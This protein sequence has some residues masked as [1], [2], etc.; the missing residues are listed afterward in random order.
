MENSMP[1]KIASPKN[2]K[3]WQISRGV[4]LFLETV[5]SKY[6]RKTLSADTMKSPV[7]TA[8]HA[9]S[10]T[11]KSVQKTRAINGVPGIGSAID[12]MALMP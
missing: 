6:D 12:F 8:L 7:V 1:K 3:G 5:K 11:A 4:R 2:S 9:A 10:P